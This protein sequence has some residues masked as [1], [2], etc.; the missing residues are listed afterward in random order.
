MKYY[1]IPAEM[2]ESLSIAR[3][4]IGNSTKG[5]LVNIGDLAVYGVERAESEGAVEVSLKQA[6]RFVK[7]FNKQQQ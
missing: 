1:I 5:Y 7:Q 3:Y 2:A 6:K 4:R